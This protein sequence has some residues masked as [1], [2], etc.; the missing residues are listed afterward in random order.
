MSE[1]NFVG[2]DYIVVTVKQTMESIYADGYAN[3]G[4]KLERTSIQLSGGSMVMKFKRDRKIS[5]K[6]ELTRLQG[7]FD[8]YISEIESLEN[9]KVIKTSTVAYSIGLLG[10][11]FMPGAVFSITNKPPI[12]AACIIIAAPGLISWIISYFCFAGISM[13]KTTKITLLIKQK[14]DEIYKI[15]EKASSLLSDS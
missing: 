9:P 10:T 13:K 4:W 12:L 6:A 7:Q 14:Y 1:K 3:F 15:C 8:S 11:A 5:N 2:Y